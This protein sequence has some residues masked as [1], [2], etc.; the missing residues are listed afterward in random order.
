[1][2]DHLSSAGAPSNITVEL[3]A[4][5][6]EI[7]DGRVIDTNS[8]RMAEALRRKGLVPR[9]AQKVDDD[10]DRIVEAFGIAQR[11]AQV[12][13]VTGGLGPTSDDITA[14][15]MAR[16]LG[17]AL[18]ESA[19]AFRVLEAALA[20]RQR[21]L[22]P[23][24]RKQAQLPKGAEVLDNPHGTAAGFVVREGGRVW[25]FMPGVPREMQPMLEE[26]VLPLLPTSL[27]Y[28]SRSWATQ[29]TAEAALQDLLRTL[30]EKLPPWLE[31]GFQTRFP[32]NHIGLYGDC[33]DVDRSELFDKTAA[34]ISQTL[35]SDCFS[36][37]ET[38]GSLEAEVV[39]LLIQRRAWVS[40]V[41]SCT[42]GLV[43]HRLTEIAG[44]SAAFWGSRLVYDN[45]AKTR[46]GLAPQILGT[47]GAVSEECA[48]ALAEAGLRD[49][50]E[51]APDADTRPLYAVATTGI[52]GP[53]G[54]TAEKPVGLCWTALA[55]R[56]AGGSVS[57]RAERVQAPTGF[58]RSQ[59][60]LYFA[61]KALDLLRRALIED[62]QS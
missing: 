34:A 11:R 5:G 45:T 36:E 32:E 50:I 24:N 30:I 10:A 38:L 44:S 28:R 7:L 3:L 17:V 47:H 22:T 49:L 20:R 60:K 40:T 55:L 48:R 56:R 19:G 12:I 57:L 2:I 62:V 53:G 42:G 26:Q 58:G 37:G 8:V 54:G 33:V 59:T 4:I 16:F 21:P 52:A 39:R 46:A 6:R 15:C 35:A 31:L 43:A 41:E 29:F 18:E 14:A 61:Q 25:A 13:L 1:M 23:A 9:Y 27:A 51:A